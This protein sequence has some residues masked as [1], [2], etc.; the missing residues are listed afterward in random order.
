VQK[1]N[2]RHI[3]FTKIRQIQCRYRQI[4][5]LRQKL[6][7]FSIVLFSFRLNHIYYFQSKIQQQ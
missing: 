6:D 4:R 2:S 5:Y 3:I 1:M 7:T